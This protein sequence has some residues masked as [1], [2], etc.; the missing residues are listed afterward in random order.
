[1]ATGGLASLIAYLTLSP[2]NPDLGGFLW[3]KVYHVIAFAA[4][5]FPTALLY[6]RSLFWVLPA[7]VAFGGSIELIQPYVGRTNEMADFLADVLGVGFGVTLGL[8][9]RAVL[10]TRASRQATAIS[11]I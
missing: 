10:K 8:T 9:I 5:V 2:P 11:Q 1:M 7:T 4:L 3:D 6:A